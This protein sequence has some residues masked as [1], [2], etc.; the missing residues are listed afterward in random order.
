MELLS[1]LGRGKG[2]FYAGEEEER[3]EK[4][5]EEEEEEEEEEVDLA[6]PAVKAGINYLAGQAASLV[7]DSPLFSFFCLPFLFPSTQQEA[8]SCYDG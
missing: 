5:K 3:E 4:E 8:I 7:V 1:S 6:L 2:P